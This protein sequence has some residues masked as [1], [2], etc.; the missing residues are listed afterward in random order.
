MPNLLLDP[1]KWTDSNSNSP[2]IYWN[3]TAYEIIPDPSAGDV[4]TIYAQDAGLIST[5]SDGDTIELQFDV[6][7]PV[8]SSEGDSAAFTVSINGAEV[9]TQD[10]MTAGSGT[11]SSP[12]LSAG[13][14]VSMGVQ[15]KSGAYG[16]NPYSGD[17]L[18]TPTGS[19]SPPVFWTDLVGTQESSS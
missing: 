16:F 9:Y 2:P 13:D 11:Y 7:T 4:A 6:L 18:I 8:S 17:F 3:G 5:V 12:P 1:N 15:V 14:S 19:V 10:C